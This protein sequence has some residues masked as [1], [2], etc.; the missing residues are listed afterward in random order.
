MEQIYARR[1]AAR[2]NAHLLVSRAI[3]DV[4]HGGFTQDEQQRAFD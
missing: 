4:L 2:G 1:V 3:R